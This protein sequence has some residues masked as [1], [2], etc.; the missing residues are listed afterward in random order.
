MLIHNHLIKLF[1]FFLSFIIKHPDG[2]NI[3]L[4]GFLLAEDKTFASTGLG[5]HILAGVVAKELECRRIP[6]V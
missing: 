3:Y 2:P 4:Q 6:L 1:Y 5:N